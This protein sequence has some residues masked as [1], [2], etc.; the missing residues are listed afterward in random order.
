MNIEQSD[1]E[2]FLDTVGI[3]ECC[4]Y[5]TEPIWSVKD[6]RNQLRNYT[7]DLKRHEH[8]KTEQKHGETVKHRI[9]NERR[10]PG[11]TW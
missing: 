3:R 6:K 1:T 11:G 4:L 5:C 2:A 10:S 9:E 7:V 8:E